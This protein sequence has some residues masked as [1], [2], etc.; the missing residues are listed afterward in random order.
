MISL[1]A[2]NLQSISVLCQQFGVRKLELFGSAASGCFDPATSD[3]DFIVDLGGYAPG[4]AA[5]YLDLI[6]ALQQLLGRS[7]HLITGDSIRNP[8]FRE[9]VDEQRITLYEARDQQAVA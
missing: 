1:I 8:Y 5:R 6:E 7:V 4:T 2:D 3:V 9:A